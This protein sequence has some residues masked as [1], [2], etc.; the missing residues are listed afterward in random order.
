MILLRFPHDDVGMLSMRD[1]LRGIAG[2]LLRNLRRFEVLRAVFDELP[3]ELRAMCA[4]HDVRMAAAGPEAAAQRSD[5]ADADPHVNTVYFYVAS[6]TVE[7]VL[8]QR[9]RGLLSRV[10][11]RLATQ[12]VEDFR[13]ELAPAAKIAEQV[14]I[15]LAAPD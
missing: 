12:L 1:A 15:L 2:P 10:N 6:A 14:N 3:P 4:P 8:E 5:S 11:A 9:K 13:F 7:A